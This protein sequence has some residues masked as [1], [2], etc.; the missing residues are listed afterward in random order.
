VRL[1]SDPLALLLAG[2]FPDPDD[3]ALLG[4]SIRAIV[5][6]DDLLDEAMATLDALELPR[7]AV[8]LLDDDTAA[9]FGDRVVRALASRGPVQVVSLGRRPHTDDDTLARVEAAAEPGVELVVSIGSGTLTDLGKLLGFRRGLPHVA[10]ATAPSMNG[11]TS[12]S[13]SITSGGLKSSVRVKAPTAVFLDT[14]VLAAA[15]PRLLRAGLGDSLARA[16]AQT[17]WLL[18]HLLLGRPYRAAPFALLAA[19]E[20]PLLSE[21]SA[22]LAGDR[23]LAHHLARTLALSGCGMTIVGSSHPASQGEHLLS[24]YLETRHR[25]P[26]GEEPLHGEQIGVTTLTMARLQRELLDHAAPPAVI[27]SRWTEADIVEHFSSGLGNV[28]WREIAPK[29]VDA[30]GAEA[31]SARLAACWDELR[32]RVAA[33][34]IA[35]ERLR[36]ILEAAGAPTTAAELGWPAPA[37]DAALRW[38][39]ALRDRYTFLDLAADVG[40]A[41][42][43]A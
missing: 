16:T 21:P 9:A 38:A 39:R 33:I 12:V 13:A 8:A 14:R 11:Y 3:G 23:R 41:A 19:D 18:A 42:F 7:R 22:L 29:L 27:A 36:A 2:Q 4:T 1:V 28:C 35:P 37:H 15:P 32:A 34:A 25:W 10:F 24:H 40:M 5:V 20:P 30:A 31:R 6:A 17:D 26:A 43:A